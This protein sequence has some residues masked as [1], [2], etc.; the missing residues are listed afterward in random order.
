MAQPILRR[1]LLRHVALTAIAAVLLSALVTLGLWRL[2]EQQARRT[3]E[4]VARQIAAAVLVPLADHDFARPGGVDRAE[5]LDQLAPFLDSGMVERVK[6]FTVDGDR[7]TIAFSD[8]TRVEGLTSHVDPAIVTHLDPGQAVVHA[9][10]DDDEHRYE[11]GLAGTRMEVFFGFRDAGG[12]DT[13][14]E[15]YVP[16]DVAGM[17]AHSTAVLLPLVLAGIVAVTVIM[18]P[19]SVAVARRR[20]QDQTE[21]R[22]IREYGLA[23][24]ELARRDLAQRL[25]DGVIPDLAGVRLL[26]ER[27][28]AGAGVRERD[29]IDRAHGLLTAD[30][31][32]LR[33]LLAELLP[34]EP[35]DLAAALTDL[36]DRI[37]RA[38]PSATMPAVDV[39]VTGDLDPRSVMLVHRAAGELLRNAFRHAN[40]S[41]IRVTIGVTPTAVTL[42]VADDGVGFDLRRARRPG[43]IGL[44][45]VERVA[46]DHDATVTVTSRRGAGTT[47]TMAVPQPSAGGVKPRRRWG[48]HGSP[49]P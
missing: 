3:A 41:T 6:V 40:A 30:V 29:M 27:V 45:L 42:S 48:S 13:R 28:Q 38:E 36:A 17:T 25:H 34:P 20:E 35:T 1:T 24:A 19:F 31:R 46:A 4:H 39:S 37:R 12:N 43:H 49:R 15:L 8:E 18:M 11:T 5:L 22:A 7:A 26:L 23:A 44:R 47:V 2:A 14:L 33:D 10:P 32:A 21:Q 16:V 9:V